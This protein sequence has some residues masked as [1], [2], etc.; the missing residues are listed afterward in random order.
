M[1][2][3]SVSKSIR[4]CLEKGVKIEGYNRRK[5]VKMMGKNVLLNQKIYACIFSWQ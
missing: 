3:W 5:A 1:E 2:T 4:K